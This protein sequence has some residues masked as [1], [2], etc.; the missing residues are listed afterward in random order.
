LGAVIY[1]LHEAAQAYAALRASKI[2]KPIVT[3]E[4]SL[5]A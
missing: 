1:P 3:F 4:P 2:L 5:F